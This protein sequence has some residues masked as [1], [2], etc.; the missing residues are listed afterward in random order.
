MAGNYTSRM[1]ANNFSK[2]ERLHSKKD[3]QELFARGSSFYLFPFKVLVHKQTINSVIRHQLLI[4]V[5]KRNF[6]RAVDR[7]AIKRRIREG[8]RLQKSLVNNHAS[9]HIGLIYTAKSILPTE[10]IHKAIA[11]VI[12]K[13]NSGIGGKEL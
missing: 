10:E 3:I 4:S 13:L 8:Y 11:S 6:K 1:I 9:L 7:N 2:S 12:K 5:S